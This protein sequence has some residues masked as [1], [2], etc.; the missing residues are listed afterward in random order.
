M[1]ALD[2]SNDRGLLLQ[3]LR[4]ALENL[5]VFMSGLQLFPL[6]SLNNRLD[7]WR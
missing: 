4:Q 5:L 3:D 1:R 6:L 7:L 2:I